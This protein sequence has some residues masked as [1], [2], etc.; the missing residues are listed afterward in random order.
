LLRHSRY[1]IVLS[2]CPMRD[3]MHTEKRNNISQLSI[4]GHC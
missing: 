4:N 3:I 2:N 1:S